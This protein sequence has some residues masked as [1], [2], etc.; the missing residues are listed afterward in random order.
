MNKRDY[1]LKA[2]PHGCTKREWVNQLFT[3][4]V[5]DREDRVSSDYPYKLIFVENDPRFH[6]KDPETGE[7]RFIEDSHRERPLFEFTEPL[8]V[9]AGTSIFPN[10]KGSETLVTT[11]GRAFVN[12]LCLVIP[13]GDAIDYMNGFFDIKSIE[14][15]ISQML[16]D[17]PEDDSITT[18]PTGKLFVKQYL[19][20]CDYILSLVA[21]NSL[22]VVSSSPKSL[23]SHPKARKM[24]EQLTKEYKDQLSDPAIVARIGNQLEQL[25]RE[26]LA[27][28]PTFNYYTI[29]DKKLFGA[30]RKKMFYMF[31]GESPFQDG[32][33][34]EFIAKSLEEGIDINHF[35]AMNN[36]LRYGSFNR[37]AQTQLGGESTKTIYR[38]LGTVRIAEDDCGTKIGIPTDITDQNKRQFIGHSII[39]RNRSIVLSM[40]NIDQYVGKNP[41][42]RGPLTCKTEGRNV[43]SVCIGKNLSEQPEGL[44]AAA[45]EI[46][47]KFL[48]AFLKKMHGSALSTSVW[49]PAKRIS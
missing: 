1:F 16:I 9:D 33:T 37:G 48:S 19:M 34:V 39:E 11:Y 32:T 12:Y 15:R 24:R 27:N 49:E 45:A 26:W 35:T 23:L 4:V 29:K 18:P 28:D 14:D 7:L 25:D 46:G 8:E 20:F 44:A 21:Y 47:G 3:V 31:G 17:D 6:F 43:C 2:L 10:Y 22:C 13:F 38:M 30:V 36:S 5:S 40:E 41:A 42:L